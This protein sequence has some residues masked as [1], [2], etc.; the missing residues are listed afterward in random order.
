MYGYMKDALF[1]ITNLKASMLENV[2]QLEQLRWLENGF[3]I[4]CSQTML[5][6]ISIDVVEDLKKI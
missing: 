2:E 3:D 5:E 6:T 4:F 1:Q